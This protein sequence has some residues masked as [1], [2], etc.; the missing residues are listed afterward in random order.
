MS[1]VYLASCNDELLFDDLEECV[2]FIVDN[3]EYPLTKT[4]DV[5]E[6]YQPEH[7]DL[8]DIECLLE[9][10][11]CQAEDIGGEYAEGYTDS[12]YYDKDK[13]SELFNVVLEWMNENLKQP[14][15]YTAGKLLETIDVT[16][17]LC[18][19]FNIDLD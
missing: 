11:Q 19:S 3:S 10:M 4:I 8:L 6:K 13:Q 17:D 7:K 5:F 9:N 14:T 16:E 1:K 2:Q 12:V 18:K 15:F